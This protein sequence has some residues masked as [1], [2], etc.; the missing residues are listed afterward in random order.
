MTTINH[1][2]NIE[3]TVVHVQSTKTEERA[4]PSESVHSFV[5]K[6]ILNYTYYRNAL[7]NGGDYIE[8]CHVVQARFDGNDFEEFGVGG[9][10]SCEP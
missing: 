9:I 5:N 8:W 6:K 2:Y 3:P 1:Y 4:S 10:H 7:A